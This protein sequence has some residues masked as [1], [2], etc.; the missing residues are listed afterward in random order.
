MLVL[1]KI[2]ETKATCI[3]L[4]KDITRITPIFAGRELEGYALELIRELKSIHLSPQQFDRLLP[5]LSY[6]DLNRDLDDKGLPI[7]ADQKFDQVMSELLDIAIA[8]PSIRPQ[9]K[10]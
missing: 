8:S 1:I 2:A 6:V 9:P 3:F 4:A 5:F 7:S 10:L